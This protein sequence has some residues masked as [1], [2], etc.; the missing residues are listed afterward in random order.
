[1]SDLYR[2][3]GVARSASAEEIKR[4][5]RKLA[6]ELHPDLNPD[7]P[8]VE[9]RFKEVSLAYSI[10]GDADKRKLY[11]SG[12]IDAQGQERATGFGGGFRRQASGGA[13]GGWREQRFGFDENVSVEDLFADLFGGLG[14]RGKGGQRQ[15]RQGQRGADVTYKLSVPFLTAVTGGKQK[16]TLSGGKSIE[17]SIPAGAESGQTLRLKGQGMAGLGG[18]PGDALIEL[19]VEPHSVFERRG[20]DVHMSLPITVTEALKGGVVTLP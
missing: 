14:G 8:K 11:D 6:K 1:M 16:V 7:D 17:V 5:Y 20:K 12:A 9:Q 15:Q 10:L 18:G 2:V 3:L 13:G 19:T 4:A